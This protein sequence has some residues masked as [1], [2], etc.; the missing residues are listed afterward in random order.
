MARIGEE[1]TVMDMVAEPG[2]PARTELDSVTLA[3]LR[4]LVVDDE[5]DTRELLEAILTQA[6]VEVYSAGS[7]SE[8]FDALES[9]RPDVII[10]DIDMPEED[11]YSFI[12]NL[13]QV[14]PQDGGATTAVALTGHAL[15]EDRK[16]ALAAGFTVHL[17]K[18]AHPDVLLKTLAEVARPPRS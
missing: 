9:H 12:R 13:R 18:P 10:S 5:M 4:V 1:A 11:G 16:K 6:G 3:G 15:P 14:M 2:V 8:A 7:V 17:G